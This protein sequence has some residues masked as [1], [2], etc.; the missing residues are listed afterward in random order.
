MNTTK[1]FPAPNVVPGTHFNAE[2]F[3][4]LYAWIHTLVAD[5]TNINR[6]QHE[7][8]L[9]NGVIEGEALELSLIGDQ[10]ILEQCCAV[11]PG[12]QLIGLI[13]SVCP[14]LSCSLKDF[15]LMPSKVYAISIQMEA[16]S[17]FT[18]GPLSLDLPERPQYT[19]PKF[20]FHIQEED[21]NHSSASHS[22]KI[23]Q[24]IYEQSEW[25]LHDYLPPCLHIGALDRL[26][27][28]YIEY[29]HHLETLLTVFPKI[30]RQTDSFRDKTMIELREFVMQCG[31]YL[32]T[33]AR[34]YRM[35]GKQA[36]ISALL[37]PWLSLGE[38]MQFLLN[39]LS[40]RSGFY[41]L[42]YQNTK[43][44][45]GLMFTVNRLDQVLEQ[46]QNLSLNPEQIQDAI[47][48]TD[49]FLEII[50][51]TFK[52]LGNGTLRPIGIAYERVSPVS[53][54]NTINTKPNPQSHITW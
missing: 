5:A 23:G 8:G 14:P 24:L 21:R 26:K 4:Q 31:S 53:K 36:T 18:F 42:L 29:T 33:Q 2:K 35:M 3:G 27:K 16:G 51:P 12:G 30:I 44:V 13:K 1:K 41:N 43:S 54:V 9:V 19:M 20:K 25:K 15:R 39:S 10:L 49:E 48:K 38:L 47:S 17:Q 34:H 6:Y 11:S 50:V 7:Y 22:L 52:A 28:K 45:N 46:I 40:D 37:K 32:S